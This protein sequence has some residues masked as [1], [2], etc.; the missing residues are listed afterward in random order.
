MTEFDD[1]R[2]YFAGETETRRPRPLA[3]PRDAMTGVEIVAAIC[4]IEPTQQ[5]EI[6]P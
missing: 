2:S 5:E 4:G 3:A 1:T 6:N